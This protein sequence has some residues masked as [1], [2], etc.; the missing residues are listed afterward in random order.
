MNLYRYFERLVR[1]RVNKLTTKG[2]LKR[3]NIER[4]LTF[5]MLLVFT[6]YLSGL[7]NIGDRNFTFVV[8]FFVVNL[9]YAAAGVMVINSLEKRSKDYFLVLLGIGIIILTLL[10]NVWIGFARF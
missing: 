9:I 2:F 4:F 7:P 3:K 10:F 6:V 5:F 8:L 1:Y